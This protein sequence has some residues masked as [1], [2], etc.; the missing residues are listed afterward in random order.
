MLTIRKVRADQVIDVAAEEL[1]KYLRM[2]MPRCGEVAID[3][4]A[5][6]ETGFRLGLLE[7]FGIPL[8]LSTTVVRIHG[9][10]RLEGVTIAQV[11]GNRQPIEETKR[12]IPCDTLLLSVG[13]IP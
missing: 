13:L 2:M 4:D 3:Y 5:K 9:E 12:F 10:K 1:K 8:Y 11:D 6:A 7:D